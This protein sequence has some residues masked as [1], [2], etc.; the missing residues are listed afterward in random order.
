[1]PGK[2]VVQ[3][4]DPA[5][6]AAVPMLHGAQAE[7][8][9]VAA[10]VPGAQFVHTAA[11]TTAAIVP[12]AQSVHAE[13]PAAAAI[14][15]TKQSVQDEEPAAEAIVPAEQLVQNAEPVSAAMVPTAHGWQD[16]AF[17]AP[18]RPKDVPTGQGTHVPRPL[19]WYVPCGQ[20]WQVAVAYSKKFPGGQS[21]VGIMLGSGDIVGMIEG[22]GV[23]ASVGSGD[24]GRVADVMFAEPVVTLLP[25]T[26][27]TLLAK[28][29]SERLLD[30]VSKAEV[31]SRRRRPSM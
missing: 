15:P 6:G 27:P 11:P 7:D 31:P 10:M 5:A 8:A 14:V 23:G 21:N 19:R 16:V 26:M 28:L 3:V 20:G 17:T 4:A 1:M 9:A 22:L 29:E 24:G 25:M 2:Q 18:V 13:A 12:A 30:T